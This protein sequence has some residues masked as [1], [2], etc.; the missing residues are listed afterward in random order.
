[1]KYNSYIKSTGSYIPSKYLSNDD[2][3]TMMDTS[4][5]WIFKRTGIKNRHIAADDEMTSDLGTKAAMKALER[6]NLSADEIDLIICGTVTADLTFPST[7]TIIQQKLNARNAFAFDVSAACSGFLYALSI[8][9]NFIKSGQIKNA[10]VIGAEVFSRILDWSDRSTCVLFGDGAGAVILSSTENPEKGILKT[11]LGSDGSL[12]DILKT[13]GG[14]GFNQKSGHVLMD[15]KSVF[16]FATSKMLELAKR[17]REE[18]KID[19]V[20]PHQA[21][22]RII[23]YL[24]S[25]LEMNADNFIVTIKD[26]ANTSAASIPLALDTYISNGHNFENKNIFL[27]SIGAGITWGGMLIRM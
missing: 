11:E 17:F 3:A 22:M 6:A 26:H 5:E 16:K 15:G 21:N 8:A 24:M 23:D 12:T 9:D 13:N 19:Y 10:L 20:L 7:A 27:T 18:Y 4:D 14:V 25:G 1:M 2:L